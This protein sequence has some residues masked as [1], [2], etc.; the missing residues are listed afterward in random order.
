MKSTTADSIKEVANGRFAISHMIGKGAFG[1]IYEAYDSVQK[2]KVAVKVVNS[3]CR[4]PNQLKRLSC[5][6]SQEYT[7]C[8][9]VEVYK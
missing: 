8:L 5:F 6:L 4:K 7:N 3:L 2:M 1:R 9:L